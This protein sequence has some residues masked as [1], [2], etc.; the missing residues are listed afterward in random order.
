MTTEP[1]PHGAFCWSDLATGDL[2]GARAFYA[3]LFGWQYQD[4]TMDDGNVYVIA[5]LPSG[6]VCGLYAQMPEQMQAGERPCWTSYVI[7]NS[8]DATVTAAVAAGGALI[9]GPMV[10]PDTGRMATLADPQ[11]AAFSIWQRD[12]VY[13]GAAATGPLPGTVCW[14]ELA[15]TDLDAA[16]RF[17]QPLFGWGVRIETATGVEY[18]EWLVDHQPVGGALAIGADWGDIPPHWLCYISVADCDA[19]VAAAATAGGGILKPPFDIPQVGRA[20]VLHDPAG[21]VFAVIALTTAS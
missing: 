15:T 1:H 10:I 5:A 12:S 20:A 18:V 2:P 6:D 4:M 9:F 16:E 19:T 14:H 8:V 3:A 7:V 17:Y 13:R 11:G 21:A